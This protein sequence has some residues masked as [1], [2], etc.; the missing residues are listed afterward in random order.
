MDKGKLKHI[1][2][3]IYLFHLELEIKVD[4]ATIFS[5]CNIQAILYV[6]YN[7]ISLYSL[8]VY[9]NRY[10]LLDYFEVQR[11]STSRVHKNCVKNKVA[12]FGYPRIS[13]HYFNLSVSHF[14]DI[15]I[16]RQKE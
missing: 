10:L 12:I 3:I 14:F 7:K 9:R 2:F 11:Y 13:I 1:F 8:K 5:L 6:E 16:S 15:Q 4:H